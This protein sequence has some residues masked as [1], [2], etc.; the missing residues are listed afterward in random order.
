MAITAAVAAKGKGGKSGGGAGAPGGGRDPRV[1]PLEHGG[2]RADRSTGHVFARGPE[3]RRAW[4]LLALA[5]PLVPVS[6]WSDGV[7]RVEALAS[8]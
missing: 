6:L 4:A 7:G 1:A 2:V 8:A 3:P 5:A